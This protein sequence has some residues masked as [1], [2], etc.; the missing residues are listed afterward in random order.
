MSA[1]S[2]SNR[3]DLSLA[4]LTSSV[5]FAQGALSISAVAFPL[6]L[7]TKGWSIAE[8]TSFSFVSGL[9]WTLKIIYGAFSDALPLGGLHR[10]PYIIL[11]SL[12]SLISWLGIAFLHSR[13]KW[14]LI[15]SFL[16]NLGFAVTDVVTD[17]LVVERSN[18]STAQQYQS[19][20]WGFRAG[21]AV[22]GGIL[23]GWL[24]Q[25]V[26]FP[27]IFLLTALVASTS[28]VAGFFVTEPGHEASASK[29]SL[30]RPIGQALRSLFSGE[31]K[32]L[33]SL[34]LVG[35]FS[36][37]FSVPLFFFMKVNLH[38][39]D[40]FLGSLSSIA[41]V[42][43]I[44][45][46]FFYS[47]LLGRFTLK[48]MLRWSIGLN[49]VNILSTFL[50]LNPLSAACISFFG[51]IAAYLSFLPLISAATVLARQRGIEGCLFALL[52]SVHNLGQLM[53]TFVGGKLF[54]Q[55]GLSTLI[56]LSALIAFSGLYFVN[57][58]SLTDHGRL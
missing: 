27:F 19:L 50:I 34:L 8:I 12:G 21:G 42:G 37:A 40:S 1:E 29:I 57:R 30:V 7:R 18:Q 47:K 33:A 25:T 2:S 55:M 13:G 22:I 38:F 20:S 3:L 15:F 9:P 53:A 11:A 26:P 5:Y 23:G 16:A 39:T 51:G 58:L 6:L 31:L 44:G 36:A 17:A 48:R 24:A 35:S 14:L 46:C 10:K 4:C 32:W 49:V 43:A 45:G 28:L 52:M 56:L 54:D 41:W